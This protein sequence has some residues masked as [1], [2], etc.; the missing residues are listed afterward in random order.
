MSSPTILFVLKT[1]MEKAKANEPIFGVA[2]G[3]GITMES[4]VLSKS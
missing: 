2:F 4:I 1:I 3:P